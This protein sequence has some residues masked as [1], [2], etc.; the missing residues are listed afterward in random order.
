MIPDTPPH[1]PC[2]NAVAIGICGRIDL[3]DRK[4]TPGTTPQKKKRLRNAA[5]HPLS[6]CHFRSGSSPLSIPGTK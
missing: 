6:I 2:A 4:N 3:I 5:I 1:T